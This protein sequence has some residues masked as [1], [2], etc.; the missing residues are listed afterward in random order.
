MQLTAH[1]TL[2]RRRRARREASGRRGDHPPAAPPE[3]EPPRHRIDAPQDA[4]S[5]SCTCGFAWDQPVTTSV[6]CPHCGAEQAW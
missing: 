4:A 5:Y 3:S 2:G 6:G 1:F